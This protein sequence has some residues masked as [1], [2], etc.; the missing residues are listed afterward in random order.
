M[1]KRYITGIP[2]ILALVV[3]LPNLGVGQSS[4]C[5]ILEK[6]GNRAVV[7]CNGGQTRNIELGGRSDM[8]K[9]GDAIE[10]PDIDSGLPKDRPGKQK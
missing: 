7:S 10:A 6:Q 4:R 2:I 5:V 9:V 3:F 8:Y 1:K